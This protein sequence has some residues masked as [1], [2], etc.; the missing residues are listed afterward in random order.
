MGTRGRIENLSAVKL[1]SSWVSFGLL[2]A[3]DKVS[4]VD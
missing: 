3:V 2:E 1:Q 4:G